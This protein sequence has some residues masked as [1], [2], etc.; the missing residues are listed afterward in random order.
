MNTDFWT[1]SLGILVTGGTDFRG[2]SVELY[3][4]STGLSCYL[5]DLPHRR[6]GHS[7]DGTLL[8]GGGAAWRHGCLRLDPTSG[9]W[10]ES[11]SLQREREDHVSWRVN[12]EDVILMGGFSIF[13]QK[14]SEMLRKD[15]T[16]LDEPFPLKYSTTYVAL[17][18]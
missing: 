15:G 18:R 13:T 14:N 5:T 6:S 10:I 3:V 7:Q 1:D 2:G 9:R 12:N 8:C 4:P 16:V 11:H 17:H